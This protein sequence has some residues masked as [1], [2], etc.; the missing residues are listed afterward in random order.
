MTSDE[1]FISLSKF[2]A[3]SRYRLMSYNLLVSPVFIQQHKYNI[4][5]VIV[6]QFIV[7]CSVWGSVKCNTVQFL[8]FIGFHVINVFCDCI[9]YL[10]LSNHKKTR[11]D[12]F[13]CCLLL[14]ASNVH[15]CKTYITPSYTPQLC[16]NVGIPWSHVLFSQKYFATQKWLNNISLWL[17]LLSHNTI[18][19]CRW[20]KSVYQ[21]AISLSLTVM[22]LKHTAV[23]IDIRLDWHYL[24]AV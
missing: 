6:G 19:C 23:N 9:I 17:W 13:C 22:R 12:K 16:S 1:D 21:I 2:F 4:H 20:R 24:I 14:F 10:H 5:V 7:D 15:L 11:K 18:I 8:V 3:M